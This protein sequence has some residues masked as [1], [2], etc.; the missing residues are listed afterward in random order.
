MNS[1]LQWNPNSIKTDLLLFPPLYGWWMY[2]FIL[3][4]SAHNRWNWLAIIS[5]LFALLITLVFTVTL[6]E[7][8]D[9]RESLTF[10]PV[11]FLFFEL[12]RIILIILIITRV[13]QFEQRNFG[14]I[15]LLYWRQFVVFYQW[16]VGI[17]S[18]Q[19]IANSYEEMELLKNTNL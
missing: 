7:M 13:N 5:C 2:H 19:R 10:S 6:F 1:P 9:N 18:L 14:M 8:I 11:W 3:R 12:V 15:N 16:P 17:W 4:I